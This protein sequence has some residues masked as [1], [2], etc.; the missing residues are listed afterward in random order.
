MDVMELVISAVVGIGIGV[1]VGMLGAGGGI[2][3]VPALVYLLGQTPHDAAA[4]SLV[5][6]L[7]SAFTSLLAH[8]RHNHVNWKGGM[9]FAAGAAVAAF[10]GARLA[11]IGRESRRQ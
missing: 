1:V 6:V 8:S 5:I 10:G 11:Q 9:V 3:S 2:L 4:G 7:L